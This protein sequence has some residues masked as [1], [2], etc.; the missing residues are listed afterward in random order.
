MK[1]IILLMLSAGCYL[2]AIA[3]RAHTHRQPDSL[4]SRWALDINL[5]GGLANKTFT[6]ANSIPNYPG[7][8]NANQGELKYKNGYSLGA[9][10]QLGFFFGKKRHFG[11]GTGLHLA[12]QSGEA[13]L[14]DFHIDTRSTDLAG[15]TYR[16]IIRGNDV[17]EDLVTTMI[18]IPLVLKYKVRFSKHWGFAMDAGA[19]INVQAKNDYTTH[20]TFDQE[21]VYKFVQT[22]DGGTTSVYDDGVT[23]SNSNWLITKAEFLKNN[24][25]GDW[26]EYARIKRSMGINV[27]DKMTT[28]S[29]TG[30]SSYQPGSIGFIIQP[31][32]SFYL[33]DNVALNLGGYYIMQTFKNDAQ[34]GYR[35]TDGNGSYS[36]VL[37]NV[38]SVS[39]TQYGV[40]VGARFFMG[41]KDRDH[42]GIP[43]RKDFCP[44]VFGLKE[45]NGCPD[46]DKDGIPDTK[47][48]CPTV[49]GLPQYNGCPD[50]DGDS[51]Q[52][53]FDECPFVAGPKALNGCPDRDSDGVADKN[54]L[55]PDE[56]GLKEFQ[57]CP[58][59]DKDG[60]PDHKDKCP[61]DAGLVSNNGCPLVENDPNKNNNNNN[62]SPT[63]THMA[64]MTM[65]ILFEVNKS[66]I[67]SISMPVIEDAVNE[68]NMHKRSTIIIDGHADASG[69]ESVNRVLSLERA[70]AVRDE[71][72]MRGVNTNRLKTVGHGSRVPAATNDTYEGKEQNRR[73]VMRLM[74]AD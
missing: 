54:D 67:H 59:T 48:S 30:S 19:L 52:D 72:K 21:A 3:Q 6:V 41:R 49:W 35:L 37:N 71:L 2:P 43:D 65:P 46:T 61:E 68:L 32:V 31:S 14:N 38:T 51:T 66:K 7:A 47:D 27:G 16:N 4:S 29:R 36:S 63:S 18:N 1:N 64:N 15:N 20:A 42:D 23:P 33:S 39:N 74:R 70:N 53:K 11:I 24:P 73:A 44:D 13:N 60:V 34:P 10:V 25:N 12:S 58:D 8:V 26:A 28:D 45:F 9:N 69:P 22:I 17:R 55:C 5:M 50:T 57:G 40:N 56:F 62:K